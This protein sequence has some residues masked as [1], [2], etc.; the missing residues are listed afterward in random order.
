MNKLMSKLLQFWPIR[1]LRKSIAY[2][3]FYLPVRF[4]MP[5]SLRLYG[6]K[7]TIVGSCTILAPAKQMETILVGIEYLRTLDPEM[8]QR[9]TVENRYLF[10]YHP[11]RFLQSRDIFT[12]TD[13]FLLWGKE[14]IAICFVQSVLDFNLKYLP[15]KRTS[16]R[17]CEMV[18]VAR[19]EIQRQVFE[20]TTK[21][22][23]PPELV[24]QYRVFAEDAARGVLE[25]TAGS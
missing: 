21:H 11:K 12:I 5:L 1:V 23:F 18:V 6:Y 24:K 2:L 13:N 7:E 3:L 4:V 22:S 20:W 16:A 14:G 10:W 15:S 8:F 25:V 19:R 17:N 9:L